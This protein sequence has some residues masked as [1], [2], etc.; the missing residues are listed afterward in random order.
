MKRSNILLNFVKYFVHIPMQKEMK[1]ITIL[2]PAY[3]EALNLPVLVAELNSLVA[4]ESA[5]GG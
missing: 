4:C 1:K 5:M 2:I 3:N